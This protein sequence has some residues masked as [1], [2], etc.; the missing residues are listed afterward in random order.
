MI[1]ILRRPALLMRIVSKLILLT[2]L[3]PYSATVSADEVSH[4]VSGGVTD[5]VTGQGIPALITLMTADSTVL[6]TTTAELFDNPYTGI[7]GASYNFENGV[8]KV[9]HYIVKA[10]SNGY[11][12]AYATFKLMSNRQRRI[13]VPTINMSRAWK[14]LPEVVV[15]ATKVK[16]VMHGDTIVY[17]ADAFNLAEGSMLDALVAKLPGCK[18]TRDGQIYVNGRYVESLLVDGHDFFGG[19]AQLALQN[20]PAYTVKKI[21]VYNKKGMASEMMGRDMN[22]SQYVMDVRLKKEYAQGYLGNVS[23]GG[24]TQD[25]Y[26][27]H[28]L[29]LKFSSHDRMMLFANMNNLNEGEMPDFNGEWSPQDMPD[30]LLTTKKAGLGYTR[31][32]DQSMTNW[33]STNTI[34]T[35]QNT[36]DESRTNNQ[37]LLPDGDRFFSQSSKQWASSTHWENY[38]SMAWMVKG[39]YTFNMVALSYLHRTRWGESSGETYDP[40]GLLNQIINMNTGETKNYDVNLVSRNNFRIFGVDMFDMDLDLK[41]NR[42][43]QHSFGLNDVNYLNGETARDY[44]DNYLDAPHQNLDFSASTGYRLMMQGWSLNPSYSYHYRYNK[45]H[46]LLY[47]LDRLND[48]DSTRFDVLPS[49]RE[50][51]HDVMDQNNS[52]YWRE[53]RNEHTAQLA[54]GKDQLPWLHAKLT[55]NLPVRFVNANL[56]YYRAGRYDVSRHAAFFEP[57]I[58]LE[59]WADHLSWELSGGMKS[60]LPD[61]TM[62]VDYKD[63]SDPLNTR[64]GNGSLHNIH[65]YNADGSIS[66]NGEHQRVLRFSAGW[67]MMDNAVAYGLLFNR[68]TGTA[69]TKPV[70]IDG[71]WDGN[72]GIGFNRAFGK[73]DKFFTDNEI[74]YNYNHSVD[75]ATSADATSEDITDFSSLR[76]IVDNSRLKANVKLNYRPND[77]YEFALHAGGNYSYIHGQRDGFSDIHAG[78]YNVGANA[79]LNLPWHFQLSTDMTMFARR[80]YQ[81]SE[82]NTT[83]WV[84]NAQLTRSF[85]NG[86]L[87]AKLQAYD[88]LHELST[89]SYNVNEQGRTET[90]RNS[91]PRYVML[92][93]TWRFNYNPKK[94]QTGFY[95]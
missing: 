21:K 79:T 29:G 47:R 4:N 3:S 48:Y 72:V 63:D 56:Y 95:E 89:T 34:F 25:R 54:Y 74:S 42:L 16:M 14:N 35:H 33:V 12:T 62:T 11:E 46:N 84:W 43:K 69:T 83:D 20:L 19:N 92:S 91:I 90:W 80:G 10:E 8:T 39:F 86:K 73:D 37:T 70:S 82:M 66:F 67:H 24:G 49:A 60:D 23:A 1:V 51:M 65:H 58:K 31:F 30:G 38:E 55:V 75:L 36:D 6:D 41:Y 78:D 57:N 81:Q 17:N 64:Y 59:H 77:N 88:I 52:Y 7:K 15:K 85:L 50:M 94:I 2:A 87:L 44:R 22:D 71:N 40:K 13:E 28:G 32:F 5:N 53:Y 61:L 93:L 9:G 26:Q 68:Q 45:T 18:L 76:S 27:L